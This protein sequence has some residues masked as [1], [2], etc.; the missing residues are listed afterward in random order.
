MGGLINKSGLTKQELFVILFL[1]AAFA[2]GLIIKYSGW[3]KP[4][5]YDYLS[6]DKKFE[7]QIK[8]SFKDL[9]KDKLTPQQEFRTNDLKRFS[10][11][12]ITEKERTA[13]NEK[14]LNL[15][16]KININSAYAADLQLLPGIGEIIAERIIEYREQKGGFKNID[17]LRKIKGIGDKKFEKIKEYITVE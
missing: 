4:G 5:D 14:K 13:Q 8:L 11:S 15:G 7:E 1:L 6:S 16:K 9:E 2:A 3:Q 17:D 10:D 12:L